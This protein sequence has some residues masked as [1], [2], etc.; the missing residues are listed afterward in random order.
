VQAAVV[1]AAAAPDL[2]PGQLEV[3]EALDIRGRHGSL[4]LSRL[5]AQQGRDAAV[6]DVLRALAADCP[7]REAFNL[8][9]RCDP[10]VPGLAG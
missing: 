10:F 3:A 5:I 2:H 9:D 8:H 7:K 6:P 4:S 1:V